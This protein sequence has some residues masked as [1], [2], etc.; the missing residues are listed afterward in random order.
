MEA[1]GVRSFLSDY[2]L[3]TLNYVVFY[4]SIF[5]STIARNSAVVDIL[6]LHALCLELLR[7]IIRLWIEAKNVV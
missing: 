4:F 6:H 1:G 7:N 2:D 5:P 3:F